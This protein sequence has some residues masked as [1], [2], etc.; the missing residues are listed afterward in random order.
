MVERLTGRLTDRKLRDVTDELPIPLCA[1]RKGLE[2]C[3]VKIHEQPTPTENDEDEKD[4]EGDDSWTAGAVVSFLRIT[5]GGRGSG[6][7]R[8]NQR[9]IN[10]TNE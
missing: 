10:R 7:G 5:R 3:R 9:E 1:G 6:D 8:R 2:N 4:D